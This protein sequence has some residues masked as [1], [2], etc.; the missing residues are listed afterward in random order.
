M[1]KDRMKPLYWIVLVVLLVTI[2]CGTSTV[3]TTEEP[4][5]GD[6]AVTQAP[7]E[8]TVEPTGEAAVPAS[9][10]YLDEFDG[11]LENWSEIYFTSASDAEYDEKTDVYTED[12]G[13]WFDINLKRTY[14]YLFNNSFE[15]EDVQIETESESLGRNTNYISL[16]CRYDPD[17]G[18]YEFNIAASGLVSILRYDELDGKYV[19]IGEGG[20]EAIHQ[21]RDT[22]NFIAKCNGD[23]LTLTI[24]GKEWRTFT[25]KN[26]KRGLIGISAG[27]EEVFPVKIVFNW[28]D[29]TE[30]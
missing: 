29:I 1:N 3:T 18:W 24:N 13:L 7:V 21:G 10:F 6:Q 30:P 15:Y 9:P 19:V 26:L 20:S 23:R 27:S 16:V 25:D 4:A 8:P 14:I 2:A 12:G 17:L 11:G 28:M 5:I 22:N